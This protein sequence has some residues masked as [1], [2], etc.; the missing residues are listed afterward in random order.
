MLP[1]A[2]G[3]STAV[4]GLSAEPVQGLLADLMQSIMTAPEWPAAWAAEAYPGLAMGELR[5]RSCQGSCAAAGAEMFSIIAGVFMMG[6]AAVLLYV[7]PGTI[8]R[9]CCTR[10]RL[11]DGTAQN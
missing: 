1:H 2:C 4:Y 11:R 8:D 9:Q 7:Y 10:V 3:S 6:V 5:L